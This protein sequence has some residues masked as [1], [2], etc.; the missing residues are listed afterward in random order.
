MI[1]QDDSSLHHLK[2]DCKTC[3]YMCKAINYKAIS[4]QCILHNNWN[5]QLCS[6]LPSKHLFLILITYEM[7]MHEYIYSINSLIY[8]I[9]NKQFNRIKKNSTSQFVSINVI[10]RRNRLRETGLTRC[11]DR[12]GASSRTSAEPVVYTD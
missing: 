10:P 9:S 3:V 1:L 8:Y 5:I 4:R 6:I 7:L 12:F 2:T 11:Y